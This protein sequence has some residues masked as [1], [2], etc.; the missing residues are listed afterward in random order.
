MTAALHALAAEAGLQVDE[1]GF[2]SLMSEQRARAKADS[3]AKKHAH[4]DLSVYRDFLDA[5]APGVPRLG[6]A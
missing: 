3:Q 6:E 2:R 1:E 4:A 5:G